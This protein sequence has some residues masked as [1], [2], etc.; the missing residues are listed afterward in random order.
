VREIPAFKTHPPG[1]HTKAE[2][3]AM[4]EIPL[5]LALRAVKAGDP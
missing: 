4:R 2:R 1:P 3:A 5:F